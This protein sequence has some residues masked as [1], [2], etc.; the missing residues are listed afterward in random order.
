LWLAVLFDFGECGVAVMAVLMLVA[1][2]RM[3]RS[4]L[5]TALLLPF[6]IAPLVNSSIP[7][8]SFT[9]LGILLFA[10]GWAK[11]LRGIERENRWPD[12]PR[13]YPAPPMHP[14]QRSH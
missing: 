14:L 10:F 9:V 8:Y 4:R 11:G 12:L 5:M 7:D 3:R 6:F 2:W 13:G 1:L